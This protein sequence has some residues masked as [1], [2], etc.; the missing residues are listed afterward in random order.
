MGVSGGVRTMSSL[1][2]FFE[3]LAS[4]DF[5]I[6]AC[7]ASIAFRSSLYLSTC[8]KAAQGH[9]PSAASFSAKVGPFLPIEQSP[10]PSYS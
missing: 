7:V 9:C 2:F 5:D 4:I 6:S 3:L 1:C 10:D 8:R